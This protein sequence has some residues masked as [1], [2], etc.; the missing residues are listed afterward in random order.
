MA[1]PQSVAATA[2]QPSSINPINPFRLLQAQVY[3][4][5]A[6]SATAA[7][8]E[9]EAGLSEDDVPPPFRWVACLCSGV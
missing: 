7:E 3:H 8:A 5:H 2:C 6:I 9:A 1:T 4:D